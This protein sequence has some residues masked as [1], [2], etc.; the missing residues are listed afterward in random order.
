MLGDTQDRSTA[1]PQLLSKPKEYVVKFHFPNPPPLSPLLLGL[2]NVLFVYP[3]QKPL[4]RDLNFGVGMSSRI[5]IVG[6][7]GGKSTFLKLLTGEVEPVQ[8]E[9]R[10]KIGKYDQHS[11]DQLDLT[12]SPTAYLQKLF[13]LS[14]QDARSTLVEFGLEAHTHLI[15]NADLSGGQRARVAF[16]E[17]SRRAP[18]I[19]ILD[20]PTNNLD[21]ESID[22]LPVAI[23]E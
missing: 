14:Y 17:L 3:G 6:P 1:P 12:L 23:N 8:V 4:F 21:I 18:D 16:V 2:H 15:P 10:V 19:L 5:S 20:E 7:N 13:N 9:H 11:A 22:A